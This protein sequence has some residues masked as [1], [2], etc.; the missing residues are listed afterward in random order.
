MKVLHLVLLHINF[1]KSYG[2]IGSLV[3][4]QIDSPVIYYDLLC[5]DS[6]HR[7]NYH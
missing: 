7:I 5:H 2:N 4:D 6:S 3:N 1:K